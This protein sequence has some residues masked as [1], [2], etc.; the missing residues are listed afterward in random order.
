MN[1]ELEDALSSLVGCAQEMAD[2]VR[3]VAE[4][5][6]AI[7][8]AEAGSPAETVAKTE[9]TAEPPETEVTEAEVPFSEDAPEAKQAVTKEEVRALLAAKAAEDGGRHK[10]AVKALVGKYANGGT[11]GKVPKEKYP[12]LLKDLEALT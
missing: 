1:K 5:V 6:A 4:A 10:T 11:L 7:R 2:S 8:N 9:G 3:E 12:E